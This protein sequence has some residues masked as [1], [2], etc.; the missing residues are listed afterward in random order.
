MRVAV[1]GATG[2]VGRAVASRL[3]EGG[4][5]VVAL[6]R[7]LGSPL[8]AGVHPVHGDLTDQRSLSA[9]AAEADLVIHAAGLV[10]SEDVDALH[11]INVDGTLRLA[12]AIPPGVPLVHIST[13]GIYGTP[14]VRVDERSPWLP[15]NAYERSKAEAERRLLD[16]RPDARVLRPTNVLGVGHPRDALARFMRRVAH[17]SVV[18]SQ[19]A[20][21]NYV[22]VDSVAATA[23]AAGTDRLAPREVIVNEPMGLRDFVTLVAGALSVHPNFRPI[24]AWLSAVALQ[25]LRPGRGSEWI[26]RARALVDPTRIE[27]VHGEWLAGHGIDGGLRPTLVAI[28]DDYRS[29]GLL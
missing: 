17:G 22:A 26:A 2:F 5:E 27:T 28:V 21:V 24:P 8:Q 7:D 9:F 14:A 18:G 1:T 3:L 19:L 12:A 20:A 11:R 29:R 10:R 16:V 23:V 15:P 25:A 13:A 6:A 4:H